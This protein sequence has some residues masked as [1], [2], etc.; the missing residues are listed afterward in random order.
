MAEATFLSGTEAISTLR[1]A[2]AELRLVIEEEDDDA[3]SDL[4]G[5]IENLLAIILKIAV[6]RN[7][8]PGRSP[9]L[10]GAFLDPLGLYLE[11]PASAPWTAVWRGRECP[12]AALHGL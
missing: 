8:C 9:Q 11:V 7:T 10:V 6:P 5:V 4:Q 3:A 2:V 12:L 1:A